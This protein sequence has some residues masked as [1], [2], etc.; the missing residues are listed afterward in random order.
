M[1]AYSGEALVLIDELSAH[2]LRKGRIEAILSLEAALTEAE[3]RIES[4]PKSGLSAPRPYPELASD[5]EL[6]ILVR[7]YWVA[8]TP[9]DPPVI[10]AVFHD[11]ADI[12]R[13]F[14]RGTN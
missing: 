13:R 4:R 14:D 3:A 5:S 9:T 2:Y 11:S 6:W 10:L 12:P 8:Y 7:H 1:I